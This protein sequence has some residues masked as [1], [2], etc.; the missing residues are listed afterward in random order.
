MHRPSGLSHLALH[1]SPQAMI[2]PA[3]SALCEHPVTGPGLV[4]AQSQAAVGSA[5]IVTPISPPPPYAVGT[6]IVVAPA[7]SEEAVGTAIILA[8]KSIYFRIIN[9]DTKSPV[10]GAPVKHEHLDL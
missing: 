1:A 9:E 6:G 5:I 8:V 3:G 4:P 2:I 7:R 10:Q